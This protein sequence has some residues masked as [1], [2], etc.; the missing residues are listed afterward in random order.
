MVNELND[1]CGEGGMGNSFSDLWA[2][3]L[4]HDEAR[5]YTGHEAHVGCSFQ[6]EDWEQSFLNSL[7]IVDLMV[8]GFSH[9]RDAHQAILGTSKSQSWNWVVEV[10]C[11]VFIQ[12]VVVAGED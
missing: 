1:L 10:S 3:V 12:R 6:G 7:N 8:V 2:Q 5:G 11:A 9:A 4:L